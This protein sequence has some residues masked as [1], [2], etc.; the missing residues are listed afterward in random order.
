MGVSRTSR[1]DRVADPGVM[2]CSQKSTATVEGSARMAIDRK[3]VTFGTVVF[4]RCEPSTGDWSRMNQGLRK[5]DRRKEEVN[6]RST[7]RW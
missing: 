1:L 6:S 3:R 5:G 7:W 4:L 2:C